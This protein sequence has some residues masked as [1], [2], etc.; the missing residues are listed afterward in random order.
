MLT[1]QRSILQVGSK[2]NDEWPYKRHEEERQ[3]EEWGR[4]HEDRGRDGSYAT[5]S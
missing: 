1:Y 4:S 2:S 5:A 3:G